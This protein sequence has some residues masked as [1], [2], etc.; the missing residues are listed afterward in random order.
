MVWVGRSGE[1][2][3]SGVGVLLLMEGL[4]EGEE[5]AAP[6]TFGGAVRW[7]GVGWL[8]VPAG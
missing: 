2:A 5:N 8:L 6:V 1:R 7:F 3:E 4:E